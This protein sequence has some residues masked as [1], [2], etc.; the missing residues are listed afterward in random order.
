M[1]MGSL[2]TILADTSKRDKCEMFVAL[3]RKHKQR[4]K[5]TLSSNIGTNSISQ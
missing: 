5:E 4:K 1:F 3:M 2:Q